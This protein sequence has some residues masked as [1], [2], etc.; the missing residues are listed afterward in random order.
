MQLQHLIPAAF[1]AASALAAT[2]NGFYDTECQR[3]G[4]TYIPVTAAQLQDLVVQEW[5]TAPVVG[6]ASRFLNW[7]G[8]ETKC[9]SNEDNTYKWVSSPV[10]NTRH[11]WCIR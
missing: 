9:P 2:F 11:R 6:D 8:D 3:Y 5:P 1:F 7:P 4:G 10:T